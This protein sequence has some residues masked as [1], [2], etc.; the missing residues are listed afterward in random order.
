MC[1]LRGFAFFP[2]I[3]LVASL[4][5]FFYIFLLYKKSGG[6]YFQMYAIDECLFFFSNQIFIL[7]VIIF[8]K[9]GNKLCSIH[10][11]V[12]VCDFPIIE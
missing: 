6:E 9:S 11:C 8:H 10:V 4:V 7:L 3:F 2:C 5:T 1:S 12:C